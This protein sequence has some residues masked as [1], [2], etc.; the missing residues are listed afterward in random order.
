[1]ERETIRSSPSG[2]DSNSKS[3]F[4][5]PPK[6]KHKLKRE[7]AETSSTFSIDPSSSDPVSGYCVD[8]R[9]DQKNLQYDSLYSGDV[10]SYRRRFE[11]LGLGRDQAIVWTD[12]RNKPKEKEKKVKLLRY[13]SRTAAAQSAK[14]HFIPKV[15]DSSDSQSVDFMRLEMIKEETVEKDDANDSFTTQMYM[16]QCVAE[17]NRRLTE[18]P[19][20]ISLWMEFISFQDHVLE[21]MEQAR[22]RLGKKHRAL[23]ERKA[24][25]FERAIE[26]NPKSV[27]LLVGHMTLLQELWEPDRVLQRWKDLV[28]HQ[29]NQPLL[30]HGYIMY[31]QTQFTSFSTSSLISLYCKS[32][33]TLTSIVSG[34][35]KSHLPE[36][37]TMESVL[38]LF[39]LYCL[40][41][42]QVGHSEKAVACYQALI[43]FNL[44]SPSEFDSKD[45][46]LKERVQFFETFWDS[47]VPRFGESGAQGWH[48]WMKGDKTFLGLLEEKSQEEPIWEEE[49]EDPETAIISGHSLHKASLLLEDFRTTHQSLPWRPDER[50][51]ETEEDCT[52][53]ERIVLFDDVSRTL[54]QIS[55]PSLKLKLVLCFLHFLGAPSPSP[56]PQHT[57][58][59]V[60][61]PFELSPNVWHTLGALVSD[62]PT[63]EILHQPLG[64]GCSDTTLY[65]SSSLADIAMFLN[66]QLLD[67]THILSV[68]R[69]EQVCCLIYNVCN[70][71][72]GI[73]SG[74]VS[75]QTCI[76]EVWIVFQLSLLASELG[77]VSKKKTKAKVKAVQKIIKSLLR[78]EPHRNNLSLWQCCALVEHL[79]GNYTEAVRVL[80]NVLT[81]HN[82]APLCV[83]LC[84]CLLG[85]RPSL[86]MSSPP[87]NTALALH[88]LLCMFEG[89]YI[90]MESECPSPDRLLKAR[91]L[92]E[93]MTSDEKK[94][95][96]ET[97]T[98]VLCYAYM[99]YLTK[100]L[101]DACKV[102]D[103]WIGLVTTKL[104]TEQSNKEDILQVLKLVYSKL[105]CLIVHH[106]LTNSVPPTMLREV[107]EKALDLF[108]SDSY[109][110]ALYVTSE[111][112]SFISGRLRRFFDSYTSKTDTPT[113]W[114]Y[115]M[116]AELTRYCRLLSTDVEITEESS[117]GTVNRILSLLSRATASESGQYCPLLWRLYMAVMVS[118]VQC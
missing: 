59:L 46:P 90:S 36:P 28:F 98:V 31:C 76:A 44:C 89:K 56:F 112:R 5:L 100:G 69:D 101:K 81:Q 54:F 6:K 113:L 12:G 60:E 41:L 108:P 50:R 74:D 97:M 32:I 72:F 70:Q 63:G 47:G 107:L 96:K 62:T 87:Q 99:E 88:V 95:D 24:A 61:S 23:L 34:V 117:L 14:D 118:V 2:E 66:H 64:I 82:S 84:E 16:T 10:A 39:S 57:L 94:V 25:I 42:R 51:G 73:L 27:Q 48:N 15:M 37:G 3:S 115:S 91:T 8:E 111:Q 85:L 13:F 22:D 18:N 67:P 79:I 49:R 116:A 103:H 11:C 83:S 104:S 71:A 80:E 9:P 21:S 20:D 38:L 30:W 77:H 75:A 40:F 53:P 65:G 55:E 26:S 68:S 109:F 17:Y 45:L 114:L 86:S 52:D 105:T 35:L 58:A 19:H 106:S 1:M 93:K 78:L 92:A 4:R 33:T 29:P 110:L 102:L 43:E 7:A